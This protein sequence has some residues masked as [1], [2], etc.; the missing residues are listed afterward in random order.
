MS[1]LEE[2]AIERKWVINQLNQAKSKEEVIWL[3][4]QFLRLDMM[5]QNSSPEFM[6][7][8]RIGNCYTYAM[9]FKYPEV[10]RD[11]YH[12]FSETRMNFNVGFI[13]NRKNMHTKSPEEIIE[14]FYKDCEYLNISVYDSGYSE[15][16]KHDGYKILFFIRKGS[17]KPIDFHFMRQNIDG[18]W[19]HKNGYDGDIKLTEPQR[20]DKDY[21]L[22]RTLEI[23]KPTIR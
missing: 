9:D 16:I 10:F 3:Y 23:K 22:V 14:N 6:E 20:Y 15:E 13:G 1:K 7:E 21:E 12:N 2:I 19:S 5:L 11:I 17:Y 18:S 8:K 4:L